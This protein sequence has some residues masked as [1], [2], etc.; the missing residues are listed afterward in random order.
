MA[1]S[2]KESGEARRGSF[3]D[4]RERLSELTFDARDGQ[5]VVA[6]E[7]SRNMPKIVRRKVDVRP[8]S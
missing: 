5:R 7:F 4:A 6:E 3:D 2:T 1:P 8:N